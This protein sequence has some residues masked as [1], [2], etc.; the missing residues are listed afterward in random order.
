MPPM[1]SNIP[2]GVKSNMRKGAPRIS[3][4]TRETMIL[5]EVPTRVTMPP[6]SDPKAI[7]ISSA[8]GGVP[9]RRA[10]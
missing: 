4:R 5:G 7:G 6:R 9:V 8:E 10:S 1:A 3:S 2:T